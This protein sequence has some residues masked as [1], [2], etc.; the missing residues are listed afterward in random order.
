MQSSRLSRSFSTP[1]FAPRPS[2]RDT[3]SGCSRAQRAADQAGSGGNVPTGARGGLT[4]PP[5]P[6]KAFSRG[7]S[8]RA[9]ASSLL[10]CRVRLQRGRRR[11]RVILLLQGARPLDEAAGDTVVDPELELDLLAFLLV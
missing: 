1:V 6:S 9:S 2:I 7:R 8:P 10:P 4:A 5:R 11:D 3:V